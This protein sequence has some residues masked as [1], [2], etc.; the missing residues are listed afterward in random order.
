MKLEQKSLL[1]LIGQCGIIVNVY[2]ISE[3]TKAMR[4]AN[5]K[6]PLGDGLR[7]WLAISIILLAPAWTTSAADGPA[8]QWEKTF[9]VGLSSCGSSVQQTSDGGYII[10]GL[11]TVLVRDKLAWNFF[12]LKADSQGNEQWQKTF[13]QSRGQ[14]G[15]ILWHIE[16]T[17]DS[18]FIVAG[19]TYMFGTGDP[20]AY[21]V[22][23]DSNGN[24]QWQKTF[25]GT[26]D[27]YG[28]SMQQTADGGFIIGGITGSFGAG[29]YDVYL[30]KTDSV[31]NMLWQKAFGGISDDHGYSIQQTA[32]GGYIIAGQS[33][34]FGDSDGDVYLVK[35]DPTGNLLWQKTFG[36]PALDNSMSV[37][38]TADGGFI[39][40]GTTGSFGA[41]SYDVYLVKTDSVGNMLW[42]KAFGGISEDDGFSIQQTADGGYIIA[43]LTKSFG[44]GEDDVYIIKTDSQGNK[45]WEKTFGRS[46]VDRGWSVQQ[47]A[48][49][50]FIIAGE[51]D[52]NVYLIKLGPD[53]PVVTQFWQ[54]QPLS[55]TS[56]SRTD[57]SANLQQPTIKSESYVLAT[58]A[59]GIQL[60]YDKYN[61]AESGS[62]VT[63]G[64]QTRYVADQV[65]KDDLYALASPVTE[66]LA[67]LHCVQTNSRAEGSIRVDATGP[68]NTA[69][70][71]IDIQIPSD[72]EGFGSTIVDHPDATLRAAY[73]T[74]LVA[75]GRNDL[76]ALDLTKYAISTH[77]KSKTGVS[78]PLPPYDVTDPSAW[79]DALFMYSVCEVLDRQ[80][81][82]KFQAFS[83]VCFM[84]PLAQLPGTGLPIDK[85]HAEY[86]Y[87]EQTQSASARF[88]RS[89]ML[90]LRRPIEIP[91]NIN[92][93]YS[94]NVETVAACWGIAKALAHTQGYS[95][96]FTEISTGKSITETA[97]IL[98]PPQPQQIWIEPESYFQFDAIGD[99]HA[100]HSLQ[101][102]QGISVITPTEG[103]EFIIM[104][105]HSPSL[106]SLAVP[107]ASDAT[108]MSI[109]LNIL[110][111][112]ALTSAGQ[113]KLIINVVDSEH[114]SIQV[115]D[116][117]LMEYTYHA[118]GPAEGFALQSGFFTV[119]S[120]VSTMAGKDVTLTFLL[121]GDANDPNRSA[122]IIDNIRGFAAPVPNLA[123][124]DLNNNGKVNFAD[125]AA[126]AKHWLV[127]DCNEPN[128]CDGAD[129][130]F[131]KSVDFT[132]LKVF[133]KNWLWEKVEPIRAD[134]DQSKSVDFADFVILA[135]HWMNN[136]VE[137]HWCDGCDFDK[138]KQVDQAD[139]AEFAKYWLE[140]TTP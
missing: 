139:L 112:S 63:W 5:L 56:A 108:D 96:Q 16:Q 114:N 50:G 68:M 61:F 97:S 70:I 137:L 111:T 85:P 71:S 53:V 129:L 98:N 77:I 35:T 62:S 136:C 67:P 121:I 64:P 45:I 7:H 47:T 49:G 95:V 2:D 131:S 66:W 57:V 116:K 54:P 69:V 89:G 115:L 51:K 20:N 12:I 93:P 110:L 30:V 133:A 11:N 73:Q 103:N 92:V 119:T 118:F 15:F 29:S 46:W 105:E 52:R 127:T 135:N 76:A 18:G 37:Q 55:W 36:G 134:F 23:T 6:T 44:A 107:L 43:G 72:V 4:I 122:L 84:C 42:Q 125:Y 83:R 123:N 13:V 79:F 132:D 140:G 78:V 17:N 59:P 74:A 60:S 88:E 1:L 130:N 94:I 126:F 99:V 9:N 117:D 58:S 19:T 24:L 101:N 82:S 120:D 81:Q 65:A 102:N 91:T 138:N 21:L 10:A 75:I 26:G 8:V 128:Y 34:S 106:Y 124:A 90:V 40:G 87:M 86:G 41:G 27:D 48:D 104:V 33:R 32:D 28:C 25:G 39:I 38:Q 109:D 3:E 31:G 113:K 80:Y 100:T 14:Y 22:K